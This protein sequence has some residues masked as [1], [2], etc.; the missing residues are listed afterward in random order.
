MLVKSIV[1]STAAALL[2][3]TIG[4]ALFLVANSDR[5]GEAT[6]PTVATREGLETEL[7]EAEVIRNFASQGVHLDLASILAPERKPQ[8]AAA[9]TAESA[10]W[11]TVVI[12]AV[13]QPAKDGR[14]PAP[15]IVPTPEAI[16]D[17]AP[18]AD[19]PTSPLPGRMSVGTR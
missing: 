6:S 1:I 13:G 17:V 3:P 14:C 5:A 9:A 11:R 10:A 7:G 4:V 8:V 19:V 18:P 12:C 16:A 2:G 15:E